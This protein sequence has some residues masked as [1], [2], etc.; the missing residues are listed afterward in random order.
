MS[1]REVP[2]QTRAKR[3]LS[4]L[5]RVG[6]VP[7]ALLFSGMA[8]IG[9]TAVA[10]EFAK[11]MNCSSAEDWDACDHCM[12]CRK[13][14]QGVHPDLTWVTSDGAFIKLDQIRDLRKRVRF[15]PFE[16]TWRMIVIQDAQ[17]LRDESANALLKMLEEPPGQ[18]IFILLVLE[19]QMLLPTIVS[20][21]CH[22]RF[23]PLADELIEQH[24]IGTCLIPPDHAKE[25][26]RM[27][28]GSIER[29]NWLAEENR[30]LQWREILGNILS[31]EKMSMIEFFGLTARWA[32]KS[33]DLEQDLEC[34]KLWLRDIIL[35]RLINDYR[36]SLEVDDV[37][38]GL[39]IASAQYLFS[40][41]DK[42]EE[43]VQNLR[44]NANKQLTLEGV[45]LAIKDISHGQGS[46]G[47]VPQ[48]R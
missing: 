43:A 25:I 30:I 14:D 21:C 13:I 6:H 4:Q 38:K 20:R 9:K 22:V 5:K 29:A 37:P 17:K 26:A 7:H 1:L 47:S 11:A 15:R 24:L 33:E 41:Y 10:R 23:Q 31:L 18:N 34:I 46:W 12:S 19:P 42:I 44:G 39:Q 32:Q 40:L 2:G 35:S 8:G 16:G 3:F 27:A 28:E 36:P 45:C 48:R